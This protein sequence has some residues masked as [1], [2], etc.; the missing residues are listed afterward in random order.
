[1]KKIYIIPEALTICL[2]TRASIL[3]VSDPTAGVD[4]SKSVDANDLDV[5]VITDKNVWDNE[6]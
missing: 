3:V 4:T 2:N 6:W 5:K 1:M